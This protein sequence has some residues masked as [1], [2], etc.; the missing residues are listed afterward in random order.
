MFRSTNSPDSIGSRLLTSFS[1]ANVTVPPYDAWLEVEGAE[2]PPPDGCWP[3]AQAASTRAT[4]PTNVSAKRAE[5]IGEYPLPTRRVSWRIRPPARRGSVSLAIDLAIATFDHFLTR[6]HPLAPFPSE[7]WKERS[8]LANHLTAFHVLVRDRTW[9]RRDGGRRRVRR[10]RHDRVRW[11][12][13]AT[14]PPG[15][16]R[17]EEP[18][19]CAEGQG[20]RRAVGV[21]IPAVGHDVGDAADAG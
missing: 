9:A 18:D 15:E 16:D 6:L 13:D 2:L 21:Q 4:V 3:P 14:E 20:V 10:G 19:Q 17:G 12:E 8:S 1:S 11:R 7:G 5:R